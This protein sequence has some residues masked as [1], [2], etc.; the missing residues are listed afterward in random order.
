MLEFPYA[1]MKTYK[2]RPAVVVASGYLDTFI[3]CQIASQWLN[4]V[5]SEKI[6]QTD[7]VSGS[8]PITSYARPDKLFTIDKQL[9]GHSLGLLKPEKIE[10]I[11]SRISELFT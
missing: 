10:K 5:P 11:K 3:V 7:F 1:D 6:A 8:L 9:A 2:K 4:N